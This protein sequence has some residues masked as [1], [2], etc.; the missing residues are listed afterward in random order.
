LNPR[1]LHSP[2]ASTATPEA[3]GGSTFSLLRGSK[4]IAQRY[5]PAEMKKLNLYAPTGES[6][7]KGILNE[8]EEFTAFFQKATSAHEDVIAYLS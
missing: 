5:N 6:E 2:Q 4:V 3:R 8:V 1:G 7:R